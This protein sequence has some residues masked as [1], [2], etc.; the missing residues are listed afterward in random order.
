MP[1]EDDYPKHLKILK[2]IV[3]IVHYLEVEKIYFFSIII[4]QIMQKAD[5]LALLL[6]CLRH[7]KNS[8]FNLPL[9]AYLCWSFVSWRK[10]QMQPNTMVFYL[11][12][13]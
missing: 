9:S 6:Y 1:N 11:T 12:I 8:L 10:E 5:A 13:V 2:F 4:L 3:S 7:K